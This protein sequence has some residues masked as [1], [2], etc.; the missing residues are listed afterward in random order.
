MKYFRAKCHKGYTVASGYCQKDGSHEQ[1]VRK[2]ATEGCVIEFHERR[3]D[4]FL[5]ENWCDQPACNMD[6]P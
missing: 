6:C 5:N 3:R 2:L 4:E 1:F